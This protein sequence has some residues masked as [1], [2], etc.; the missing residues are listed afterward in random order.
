MEELQI[1]L[2]NLSTLKIIKAEDKKITLETK[3]GNI[4]ISYI[5]KTL[6]GR[7]SEAFDGLALQIVLNI[8]TE[9]DVYISQWGCISNTENSLILNFFNSVNMK[10]LIKQM[11]EDENQVEKIKTLLNL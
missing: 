3:E 7:Q 11:K 5:L 6:T 8:E 4:N 1:I 10:H 9:N 2:E